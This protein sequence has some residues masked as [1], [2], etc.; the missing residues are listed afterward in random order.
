[1]S[2]DVVTRWKIDRRTREYLLTFVIVSSVVVVVVNVIVVV[3]VF[4]VVVVVVVVVVIVVV[5]VIAGEVR[6]SPAI[7]SVS[8]PAL[9]ARSKNSH[10][11]LCDF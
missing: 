11:C 3:V 5:G 7:L 6:R 10:A 2:M 4:V 1:M 8:I 9:G